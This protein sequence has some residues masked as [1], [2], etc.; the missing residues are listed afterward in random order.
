MSEGI[1]VQIVLKTRVSEMKN[2]VF[3]ACLSLDPAGPAILYGIVTSW[4]LGII[5]WVGKMMGVM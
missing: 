3:S 4:V 2:H 5:Y 1:A